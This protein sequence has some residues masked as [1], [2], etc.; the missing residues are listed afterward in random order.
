[1]PEPI[2]PSQYASTSSFLMPDV[3]NASVRGVDQ[4]I[5]GALVPVLTERRAAHADDGDPVADAV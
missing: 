2:V 5:L 1:M 3:V 4:Q